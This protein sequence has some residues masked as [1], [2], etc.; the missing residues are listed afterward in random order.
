MG[1]NSEGFRADV[2]LPT[3]DFGWLLSYI[4]A[5]TP[6]GSPPPLPKNKKTKKKPKNN[7]KN[8]KQKKS[9][10]QQNDTGDEVVIALICVFKIY[11]DL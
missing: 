1:G 5:A 11:V 7:Q 6:V 3:S 2:R 9:D 8:I 4:A 10:F